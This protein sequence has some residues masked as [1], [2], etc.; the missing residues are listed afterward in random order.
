MVKEIKGLNHTIIKGD[1]HKLLIKSEK[2]ADTPL[3]E[4]LGHPHTFD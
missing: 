3:K 2:I 4:Y 1:I